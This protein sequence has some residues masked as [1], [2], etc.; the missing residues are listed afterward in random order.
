MKFK[1]PYSKLD[2]TKET[3]SNNLNAPDTSYLLDYLKKYPDHYVLILGSGN[4][5][6]VSKKVINLDVMKFEPVDLIA[7][8]SALPFKPYT[9]NAVFCHD[10]LEHVTQPFEVASEMIRVTKKNGYMECSTP[11]LFPFHDVPDHY[12]NS[13]TSGIQQLF[14]GTKL[15]DVGVK[16]GPWH[17]MNNIVGIYKKMLKRVYKDPITPW[18]EKIR[19]F[20]IYR[21]LSW[22]MKFD[23]RTIVLTKDEENVLASGVYIKTR[24]I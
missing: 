11:F 16:M 18:T 13:S 3:N 8:G 9:F 12:F 5:P 4:S 23:H 17:A 15:I 22:G 21:L 10:V 6:K 2:L 1:N 24:K 19:I 7:S 14:L 20:I